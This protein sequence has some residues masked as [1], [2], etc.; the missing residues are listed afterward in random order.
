MYSACLKSFAL[1]WAQHDRNRRRHRHN[2]KQQQ[3]QPWTD[4]SMDEETISEAKHQPNQLQLQQQRHHY[5]N[6]STGK[7]D[8][9]T[10]SV[11]L[12][13]YIYELVQHNGKMS[14][15]GVDTRNLN[16]RDC[17]GGGDTSHNTAEDPVAL[18]EAA[19]SSSPSNTSFPFTNIINSSSQ[20]NNNY[21]NDDI[22]A[23]RDQLV[24]R[25]KD[26]TWVAQIGNALLNRNEELTK[27]NEEISKEYTRNLEVS[28]LII[29]LTLY[30]KWENLLRMSS[31]FACVMLL[32]QR[33]VM[34]FSCGKNSKL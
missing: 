7:I 1:K 33:Y 3:Q 29:F 27:M 6:S 9:N 14:T 26:V 8:N 24:Q 4:L 15:N 2:I 20:P 11:H 22:D 21:D 30:K 23:L 34:V 28:F 16:G 32:L 17:G 12:D 5:H 10:N 25:D 13:D 19:I 31:V 18:Y